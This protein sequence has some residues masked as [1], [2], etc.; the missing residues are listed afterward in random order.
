ML[1]ADRVPLERDAERAAIAALLDR[2]TA[3]EGGALIVEGPAGIGKT[4]LLAGARAEAARRDL[5]VLGARGGV[6]ERELEYAVVRQLLER[7]VLGAD[8]ECRAALLSGPAAPAAGVIGA[9]PPP[10]DSGPIH[11]PSPDLL[12]G[13]GWLVAHLADEAPLLLVVDD[14]HW[15]DPASLRALAYL[16]RRLDGLRVALLLGARVAEAGAVQPLLD[17]LRVSAGPHVVRPGELTP[18]GVGRLLADAFGRP[19]DEA[20]A[21]ACA[22]ATGG[23]PFFASELA[24]EL[25]ASHASP[26][27][28]DAAA[29]AHTGPT[30]VRRSLLL[31]LGHLGRPARALAQAVAVLG[32]EGDLALAG[33]TAGLDAA[34]AAEGVDALVAAGLLDGGPPLRLLHPLVRAAISEDTPPSDRAAAHRRA[35]AALAGRGASD[36]ALVPHALAVVPEGD[37]AV[38]GLLHRAGTRALR[39]G[40][41]ES[42]VVHL[43]RALAEPPPPEQRPSVLAALGRAEIRQGAFADGVGH[44]DHALEGLRDGPGRADALRDRAF[45]A[46]A[47]SGMRAA[48]ETVRA[49]V[50]DLAGRGQED[51]ALLLEADLALLAW[52]SGQAHGLDLGRHERLA[53]HTRAERTLLALLAQERHATGAPPD[54]VIELAE[55]ALAGGRLVAEDTSEALHWYM[56]TYA[57]LTCEAH[58]SARVTIEDA[59]ADGR[60]RGSAFAR[61]GALGTRAVLALN[62]GRPR[63]AEADARSASRGA[64]PPVMAPVRAAYV[65]LA[66]VDQGDL[67]GAEKT[68]V[69]GGLEHGPGGPTVLRWVPWARLRLRE[70]Q[71]R[72][73]DVLADVAPLRDDDTA[74]SPMRALAWRALVARALARDGRV[75]EARRHADEHLA[76]ARS[77]GRPGALGVA[78]RASALAGPATARAA[79][80]DEAVAV[81]ER[82]DL[83]TEEARARHALGVAL[84]RS[85]LRRDGRAALAAAL[86]AAVECGADGVARAAA[87]ELAVAGVPAARLRFDALTP[88]ERRVAELAA[89]GGTNREIAQELFVTPKTVENHLTRVYAKLGVGSREALET[90]L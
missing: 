8:A 71:G 78:L 40:A 79:G 52:L 59:L 87:E 67:V 44:L 60:R 11:D 74:G 13:L 50:A 85:G 3:G 69:A 2:A 68:L 35:F 26:E 37:P 20:L 89:A 81:L 41:P 25:A 6:L 47:G 62:Q 76:W 39:S 22:A 29:V 77:W 36:D 21:D 65:V 66:L 30:A 83:R 14:A 31:R 33:A 16:A 84:L 27:E 19:V 5:R 15:A 9:H 90:A 75:E 17:E 12:H 46:F 34:D 24:A 72:T 53:G 61:A 55:R 82:S 64:T 7:A 86:E 45:A 42:A 43:R 54:V 38:V 23:N 10:R 73:A 57:L 4:T 49:A 28:V 58:E 51:D 70:A 32:G 18:R 56:A 88:S 80:L 48:R 63:D 1:R